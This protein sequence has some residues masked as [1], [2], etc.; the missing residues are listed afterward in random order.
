MSE[1]EDFKAR[2]ALEREF[3]ERLTRESAGSIRK[4]QKV[5]D[6][7][8]KNVTALKTVEPVV[9]ATKAKPAKPHEWA[10][11]PATFEGKMISTLIAYRDGQEYMEFYLD[12]HRDGFV[13][14]ILATP[15]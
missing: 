4:L 7:L 3:H 9:I 5:V 2:R 10:L 8:V 6:G 14:Q 11:V 12:R 15:L 1:D 13:K